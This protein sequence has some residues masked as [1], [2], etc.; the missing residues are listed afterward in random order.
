MNKELKLVNKIWNNL[1]ECRNIL[2]QK[3]IDISFMFDDFNELKQVLTPIS[4][5]EIRD[6]ID[7][8]RLISKD[9][10]KEY[11]ID[12]INFGLNDITSYISQLE[13]TPT[14]DEIVKLKT[15]IALTED[16]KLIVQVEGTDEIV[17]FD[18]WNTK[19]F[20]ELNI[21]MIY[22]ENET[23]IIY[24]SEEDFMKASDE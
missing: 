24:I 14:S 1:E 10:P 9:L 19:E 23:F 11:H 8:I 17:D 16:T 3:G 18:I 22:P 7:W 13:S 21:C 5:D 12:K 2:M 20:M 4:N 6:K 15:F